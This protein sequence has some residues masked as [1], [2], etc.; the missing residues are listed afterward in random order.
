MANFK[1]SK[2]IKMGILENKRIK[3]PPLTIS[4]TVLVPLSLGFIALLAYGLF[5]VPALFM[6]D[7]TSVI[8]RV[9]T[10]NAIWFDAS[11]RRPLLFIPFL[12]QHQLFG[13]NVTAYYLVL[14]II[15]ILIALMLYRIVTSFQFAYRRIFGFLLVLIFLIYPTNYTHMWLINLGVF[16]ANLL[17]LIYAYLLLKFATGGSWFNLLIATSLLLIT[18]GVYEGQIGVAAAWPFLLILL[19]RKSPKVRIAG[20]L[21]PVVLM[22]LYAIW[23]TSGYQTIG[24]NDRYLS[25]MVMTPT[26]LLSRLWLGFK[27]SMIWGWTYPVGQ[28]LPWFSDTKKAIALLLIVLFILLWL[29]SRVVP[30]FVNNDS[31]A[32]EGSWLLQQRWI[33]MRPYFIAAIVGI[34][35]IG[36]GYIPVILVFLPSL[37]GIGSRFNN[38]ASIGGSLFF[39]SAIM[40]ASITFARNS[41]QIKNLLVTTALPF[42]FLGTL[43]QAAVQYNNRIAWQEQ[44]TIWQDLFSLAPN[45][46]DDTFVLFVL[47]GYQERTGFYNWQRTPLSASWEVT[48]GL[49]LLYNNSTL[50]GDVYFPDIDEPIEPMIE[51]DGLFVRETGK[52]VPYGKIIAVLFDDH[53][54]GLK[55]LDNLPANFVHDSAIPV[56]LCTDCVSTDWLQD[57][58]LRKLVEGSDFH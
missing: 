56:H 37:S 35:F 5:F 19:Y 22:G 32:E 9:V 36:A 58:P 48:S 25:E 51:A 10:G 18:F 40:I 14:W 7:W 2:D 50:S 16:C 20:L 45:I 15:N 11:A 34:L 53:T 49:H 39:T 54:G 3:I 13:L 6:D 55:Q 29:V 1:D 26:V 30:R 41:Q 21:I 52:K 31:K 23:R 46:K 38:Y 43:T 4:S 24:I 33:L 42:I 12:I 47:P 17:L 44:T 28:F 8:E 27:I 57:D